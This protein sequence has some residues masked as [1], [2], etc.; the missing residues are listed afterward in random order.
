MQSEKHSL[1]ETT[2]NVTSSIIINFA[3]QLS[4]FKILNIP[5]TMD[6]NFIILGVFF[7]ASFIR[8]Y[9]IRRAFA[10]YHRKKK[11]ERKLAE[12]AEKQNNNN[13]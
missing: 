2:V 11:H 6:K 5:V 3:I 10:K 8:N 1:I 4:L 7:C 13:G 9:L 12:A